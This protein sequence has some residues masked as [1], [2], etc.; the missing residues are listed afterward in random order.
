[1]QIYKTLFKIKV[2]IHGVKDQQDQKW[3][4]ELV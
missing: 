1:M 2:I 3:L 4:T